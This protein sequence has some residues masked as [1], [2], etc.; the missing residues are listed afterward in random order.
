MFLLV[1]SY[2]IGS[3]TG[4]G[5]WYAI[6]VASPRGVGGLIHN[7]VWVCAA[8]WVYFTVEV[9]VWSEERMRESM[10]KS[11]MAGQYIYSNRVIAR[12]GPGK[13]I[14]AEVDRIA[15]KG[16][17]QLHPYVPPRLR[18]VN[19]GNRLEAGELLAKIACANC[20]RWSRGRRCATSRT[21]G[22]RWHWITAKALISPAAAT[23]PRPARPTSAT[24]A[25]S[26]RRSVRSRCASAATDMVARTFTGVTRDDQ[27]RETLLGV[28]GQTAVEVT[29]WVRAVLG[30]RA[31]QARFDVDSLSQ[32][33]NSGAARDHLLSP[34]LAL[35]L[36]PLGEDRVLRQR[37]ARLP[38]Q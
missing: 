20:M 11:Y 32:P 18:S 9:G 16:L 34:K 22:W 5:I 28:N 29:P 31:D 4:P 30:L 8:E 27:V 1:F 35:V 19:D 37:R 10:R 38:Q 25:A 7:F 24:A 23:S 21:P 2:I 12:H 14:T 17:L 6:T 36:G 33:A 3:I 15:E 13:G 26:M